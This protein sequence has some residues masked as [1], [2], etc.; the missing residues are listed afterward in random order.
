LRMSKGWTTRVAATPAVKPAAVSTKEGESC[1]LL[2][3]EGGT[4]RDMLADDAG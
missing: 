3:S 4:T 1:R 2:S